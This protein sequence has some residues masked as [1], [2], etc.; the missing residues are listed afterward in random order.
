MLSPFSFV[1]STT[2]EPDD[3]VIAVCINSSRCAW[4]IL[5]KIAL[6]CAV[7]LLPFCRPTAIAVSSSVAV[8]PVELFL[9]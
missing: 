6:I 9:R 4:V 8:K 5:F 1:Y 7:N 2:L 3:S